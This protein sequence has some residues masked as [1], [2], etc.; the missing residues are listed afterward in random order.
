MLIRTLHIRTSNLKSL[1]SVCFIAS[2][3]NPTFI[4]HKE[5]FQSPLDLLPVLTQSF[6]YRAQHTNILTKQLPG[7]IR[8]SLLELVRYTEPLIIDRYI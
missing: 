3:F 5:Y 6:E 2:S 1:S 7:T 4:I 8:L